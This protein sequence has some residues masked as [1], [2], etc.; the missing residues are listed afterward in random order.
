MTNLEIEHRSGFTLIEIAIV[1]IVVGLIAGGILAGQE[2]LQAARDR[3]VAKQFQE[4]ALATIAF[5]NKYNCIPGDCAQASELGLGNNG[6]GN[7]LIAT[8]YALEPYY[9]WQHLGNAGLINGTYSGTWGW[10]DGLHGQVNGINGPLVKGED[11]AWGFWATSSPYSLFAG[12]SVKPRPDG[13]F[14]MITKFSTGWNQSNVMPPWRAQQLDAKMDDGLPFTG[15][16]VHSGHVVCIGAGWPTTN[17]YMVNTYKTSNL[18]TINFTIL[19][20]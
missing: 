4:Y 16:V 18:C 11:P 5:K 3:N 20:Y 1:F 19:E 7:G 6:D 9:L 10:A 13:I 15:K 2:L 12:G 17:A 8:G 14:I